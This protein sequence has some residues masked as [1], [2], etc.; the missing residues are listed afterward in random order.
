MRILDRFTRD[1]LSRYI[2]GGF[3][4]VFLVGIV[5]AA[6]RQ[7]DALGQ[8]R[9]DAQARAVHYVQTTL[10]DNLDYKTV[11]AP[12]L[13]ANY[14]NLI[15]PVQAEIFTDPA[16]ARLR[17]WSP[18]G[19]LL[20]SSAER[21]LIGQA[22]AAGNPAIQDAVKGEV[23]SSLTR[24]TV[25]P[26]QGLEG[27]PEQL[28]QTFVPLRVP[29]RLSIVGAAEVDQRNAVIVAGTDQPWRNFQIFFGIG[30]FICAVFA[31][32]SLRKARSLVGAEVMD[33]LP[34]PSAESATAER[35]VG[36]SNELQETKDQLRQAVEA[37][38]FLEGK[39]KEARAATA[40]SQDDERVAALELELQSARTELEAAR[41]R[42]PDPADAERLKELEAQ[43]AAG[44]VLRAQI[45]R[46]GRDAELAAKADASKRIAELE[47]ELRAAR[48]QPGDQDRATGIAAS[49]ASEVEAIKAE[50]DGARAQADAAKFEAQ[51]A[52]AEAERARTQLADAQAKL[53]QLESE[54]GA[55]SAEGLDRS[56]MSALEDRVA[57]AEHRALEA[58][59]YLEEL[60]DEDE[61]EEE[62]KVDPAVAEDLRAR[63]ARTAAKKRLSVH[64]EADDGAGDGD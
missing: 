19:E 51:A 48:E 10:F 55:P 22:T 63:L 54:R 20:F 53:A 52:R 21:D 7:R 4:I 27:S 16:V 41:E 46:D 49:L 45:E 17:I 50:L 28:Y 36:I 60:A 30:V 12:I 1:R 14:R 43:L 26:K 47:G 5:W 64:D 6:Q 62:I 29:D 11:S 34:A 23:T 56:R 40:P 57:D 15:I 33:E 32:L 38:A 59:R 37:A 13:A 44:Q 31:L 3:T 8:S 61:E 35:A 39:L 9:L 24:T 18:S 58:E 42:G 25:A 2:W